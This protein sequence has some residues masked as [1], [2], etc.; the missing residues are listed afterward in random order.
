MN[1]VFVRFAFFLAYTIDY[2][3]Y[4]YKKKLSKAPGLFC[5]DN[6]NSMHRTWKIGY[7]EMKWITHLIDIL[8]MIETRKTMTKHETEYDSILIIYYVNGLHDIS[9]NNV[10]TNGWLWRFLIEEALVLMVLHFIRSFS[11]SIAPITYKA[12]V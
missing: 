2:H 1:V 5:T 11:S 7:N 9:Y 6:K 8:V 3:A 12:D 4:K 10:R